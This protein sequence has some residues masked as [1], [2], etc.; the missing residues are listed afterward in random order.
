[1]AFVNAGTC[2][3]TATA[4][5]GRVESADITVVGSSAGCCG[6]RY[7]VVSAPVSLAFSQDAS[8]DTG[9]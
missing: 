2:H 4:A 5:D 1:V 6:A 7:D 3:L 8:T 9:G